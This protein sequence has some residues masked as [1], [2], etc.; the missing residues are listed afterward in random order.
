M[1]GQNYFQPSYPSDSLNDTTDFSN[2]SYTHV[3]D[4]GESAVDEEN[5]ESK[6][7][8]PFFLNFEVLN[9]HS[10]LFLDNDIAQNTNSF[11]MVTLFLSLRLNPFQYEQHQIS[12]NHFNFYLVLLICECLN[13][14]QFE[15]C[16][17]QKQIWILRVYYKP[18][19]FLN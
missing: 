6:L 14:F 11:K 15:Y 5:K 8:F 10:T 13:C 1:N 16:W 9:L 12:M 3:K 2:S 18:K 4:M 17:F 19:N 7:K